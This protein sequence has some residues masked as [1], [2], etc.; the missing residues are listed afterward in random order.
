[1][2]M[3]IDSVHQLYYLFT[4]SVTPHLPV[5]RSTSS[6]LAMVSGIRTVSSVVPVSIAVSIPVSVT[7]SV[8][9]AVVVTVAEKA[10]EHESVAVGVSA[11]VSE[12]IVLDGPS[13]VVSAT[14]ATTVEPSF[15][16]FTISI[17]VAI[18]VASTSG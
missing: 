15:T 17:V 16:V 11:I 8:S 12:A 7:I 5:A 2:Q 9:I 6:S 1:M 18:V 4:V 3:C 13:W 10:W 14:H